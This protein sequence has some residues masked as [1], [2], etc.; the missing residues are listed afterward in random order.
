MPPD[1]MKARGR[2][3]VKQ[4]SLCHHLVVSS[5]L[6]EMQL[7][8]AASGVIERRLCLLHIKLFCKSQCTISATSYGGRFHYYTA[9]THTIMALIRYNRRYY[10]VQQL[11]VLEKKEKTWFTLKTAHHSEIV[12]VPAT[13]RSWY[14]LEL[15]VF[16]LPNTKC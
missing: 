6:K 16:L 7:C 14:S 8:A 10:K 2:E 12:G 1:T 15:H 5:S 11:Q 3:C 13:G 4:L 9:V